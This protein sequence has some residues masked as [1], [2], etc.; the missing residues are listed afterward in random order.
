MRST[1][2]RRLDPRRRH[3]RPFRAQH[4]HR[5][6]VVKA[7]RP[8]RRAARRPPD[9][10]DPVDLF[11]DAFAEAGADVDDGSSTRPV[12]HLHRTIQ[13]IK[14]LGKKAGVSLN[15][16]TPV[17][18]L[19]YV[20]D[21]LDLVLVM[22]VNPGFGGQKFISSQLRKIETIAKQIAVRG[23][24]AQLEVDG[25]SIQKRRGRRS[26]LA[27]PRSS[28]AQ[29]SS[30]AVPTHTRATSRHSGEAHERRW[31]GR[32]TRGRLE[33][34]SGLALLAPQAWQAAAQAGRCAARSCPRRQATRRSI[35]RR[36]LH[37]RQRDAC[38][39]GPRPGERRHNGRDRRAAAKLL[40]APR[41]RGR[42]VAGARREARRG[43]GRPLAARSRTK[44]R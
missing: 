14:A 16:A 13:H 7:L 36:P 2:G 22:S 32:R 37:R 29:R 20:L 26:T 8:S 12:P 38:A 35:A 33:A 11:L 31:L 1:S 24:D 19:D 30:A 15:P 18:A 41:S 5:S 40:L 9:D 43:G 28:R 44:G 27:R 17:D 6:G 23:L 10:L 42:S 3:G 4:H 34:R 39:E 21:D 25:G